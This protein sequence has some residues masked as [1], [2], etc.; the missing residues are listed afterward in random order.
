MAMDKHH[1]KEGKP[2]LECTCSISGTARA[3]E[4]R[5]S[6]P[7]VYSNLANSLET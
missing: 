1:M 2:V 5:N 3:T 7:S 6:P 4:V